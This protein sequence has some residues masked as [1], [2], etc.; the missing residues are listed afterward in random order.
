MDPI[1]I[2]LQRHHDVINNFNR[3]FVSLPHRIQ[4]SDKTQEQYKNIHKI[5]EKVIKLHKD[6]QIE[7]LVLQTNQETSSNKL[8]KI[9][10]KIQV[11]LEQGDEI[12]AEMARDLLSYQEERD[13]ARLE[14]YKYLKNFIDFRQARVREGSSY[15]ELNGE[16]VLLKEIAKSFNKWAIGEGRQRYTLKEIEEICDEFFGNSHGTKKYKHIRVFLDEE[17]LEYFEENHKEPLEMD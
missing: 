11:E 13:K 7:S 2:L 4:I 9:Q 12:I 8:L 14:R 1:N 5:S 16:E 3:L 10:A 17:D 6:Y 15:P